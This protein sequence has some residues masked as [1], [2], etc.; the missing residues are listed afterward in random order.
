MSLPLTCIVDPR[1]YPTSPV[2]LKF[3]APTAA[4]YTAAVAQL[5]EFKNHPAT[6]DI[7]DGGVSASGAWWQLHGAPWPELQ[8]I[9]IRLFAIGTSSCTSERNFSTW[10]HV[11]SALASG[12]KFET[13]RK[14]VYCYFNI[15][16]LQQLHEGSRPTDG[17]PADWLEE[18]IEE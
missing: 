1:T 11:W 5:A 7:F 9:C 12:L 14:L 16:A 13:A 18:H 17:V 10:S 4:A 3:M 8:E 6:D 15:R 2:S